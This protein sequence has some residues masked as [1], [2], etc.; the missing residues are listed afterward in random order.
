MFGSKLKFCLPFL[1]QRDF[2]AVITLNRTLN[3]LQSFTFPHTK[4]IRRIEMHQS[5]PTGVTFW[6]CVHLHKVTWNCDSCIS[7]RLVCFLCWTK[8]MKTYSTRTPKAEIQQ[9]IHFDMSVF[10]LCFCSHCTISALKTKV[11]DNSVLSR[12]NLLTYVWR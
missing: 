4:K 5:Q 11:N 12:E 2:I 6:T 3:C 9:S 8:D 1:Y 7:I 10:L